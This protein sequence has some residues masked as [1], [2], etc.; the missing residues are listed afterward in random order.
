[1]AKFDPNVIAIPN[2]NIFGFP[3]KEEDADIVLIPVP[4]DVT[5]SYGKG[6][7]NGPQ[8]ILDASLQ[9][10]FY[11]HDLKSAHEINVFFAPISEEW[12]KISDDF[13][14]DMV[15]YIDFLENGGQVQS[16]PFFNQWLSKVNQTQAALKENLKERIRPLLE[17]GKIIGIIGGEHSTPLALLELLSEQGEEFGVLQIDAHADLRVAY[18]GFEQSHASIMYNALKNCPNLTKLT[19]VGIRDISEAE[20]DIINNSNDRINTFYDWDLKKAQ[21]EGENWSES[22]QKIIATLPQKV[23]ISYDI[24]GLTPS[25]CPNTG[26]PVPGGF[27]LEQIAYLFDQLVKS[28]RKIIAFDFCE[29]SPGEN[30]EW[31]ANVGSRVLWDLI[32]NLQ[33]QSNQL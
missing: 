26:T 29:V 1:M 7:A 8:A 23:Y 27:E 14:P 28:G 6:T 10:D 17:D 15:E 24:D 22:V 20:V 32:V 18:E 11:R 5:A 21:Y 30:D 3:V 33:K 19:Q 4:W 13:Q 25:L 2:G 12:K 16:N 31:D 9:L